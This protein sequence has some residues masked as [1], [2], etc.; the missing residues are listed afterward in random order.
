MDSILSAKK[1]KSQLLGIAFVQ[2]AEEKYLFCWKLESVLVLDESF[3]CSVAQI[4][5]SELIL[6]TLSVSVSKELF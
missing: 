3:R 4:A 6:L 2:S 5:H 1:L